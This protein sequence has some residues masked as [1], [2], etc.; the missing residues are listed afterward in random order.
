MDPAQRQMETREG[1]QTPAV[2]IPMPSRS[3]AP[4]PVR[5]EAPR[6]VPTD[7]SEP[8]EEPGYGHGV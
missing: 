5:A 8:C 4:R 2:V 3:S 7:T 1:R 6:Q